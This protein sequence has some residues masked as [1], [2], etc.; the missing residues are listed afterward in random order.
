MSFLQSY[1]RL[2]RYQRALLGLAGVFVG[3]YGPSWMSHLF[4]GSGARRGESPGEHADIAVED[5]GDEN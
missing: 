1:L 5:K 2:P 3:W 4:L